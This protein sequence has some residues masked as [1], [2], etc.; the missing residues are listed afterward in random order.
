MLRAYQYPPPA[1]T[2][3]TQAATAGHRRTTATTTTLNAATGA[4]MVNFVPTASPPA[5]PATATAPGIRDAASNATAASRNARAAASLVAAPGWV[6]LMIGVA[7]TTAVAT[8]V[9]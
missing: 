3:I 9:C 2:P 5:I 7:R 4:T 8:I 1:T 6:M